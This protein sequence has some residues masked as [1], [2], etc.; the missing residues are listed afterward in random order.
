M[1][2]AW[3]HRRAIRRAYRPFRRDLARWQE[4]LRQKF[5]DTDEAALA[6][7]SRLRKVELL[8]DYQLLRSRG[9]KNPMRHAKELR[10]LRDA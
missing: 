10:A 4:G 5:P 7:V 8:C 9:C 1:F 3:K 2:A 6:L